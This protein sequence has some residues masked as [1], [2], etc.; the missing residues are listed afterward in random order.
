[1]TMDEETPDCPPIANDPKYRVR[2]LEMP[3]GWC[4]EMRERSEAMYLACL[5]E[6]GYPAEPIRLDN[7]VLWTSSSIIPLAVVDRAREL[8]C[9]A[10]GVV[11]EVGGGDD[12]GRGGS[13]A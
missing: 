5:A 11:Y 9:D 1:M 12:T 7:G 2:A 3:P 10:L 4:W 8:V 6:A 13:D